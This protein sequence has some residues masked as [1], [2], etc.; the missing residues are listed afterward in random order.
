MNGVRIGIR[1][2]GNEPTRTLSFA[3][4]SPSA[5]ANVML[6]S[7]ISMGSRAVDRRS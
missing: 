6:P 2:I 1:R 4:P 3:S 5:V 7:R